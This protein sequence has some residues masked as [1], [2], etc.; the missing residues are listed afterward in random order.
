MQFW[1]CGLLQRYKEQRRRN[2][3][4]RERGK[5]DTM[6]K[7]LMKGVDAKRHRDVKST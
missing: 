6:S 5:K 3:E 1:V 2:K 7:R 4:D